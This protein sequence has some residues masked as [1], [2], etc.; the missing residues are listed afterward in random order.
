MVSEYKYAANF[1]ERIHR[2]MQVKTPRLSFKLDIIAAP[3]WE[4]MI[5]KH[6]VLSQLL[7][8]KSISKFDFELID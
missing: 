5:F 6:R 8:D 2:I 3:F 7:T 4:E 1:I